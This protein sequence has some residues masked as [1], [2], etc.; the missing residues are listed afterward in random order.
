MHASQREYLSIGVS[1]WTCTVHRTR[2]GYIA[3]P[4]IFF[5]RLCI[6]LKL[7]L[8]FLDKHIYIYTPI[9]GPNIRCILKD[10]GIHWKFILDAYEKNFSYFFI[11]LTQ[12]CDQLRQ[13]CVHWVQSES[14][15]LKIPTTYANCAIN[16]ILFTH[17]TFCVRHF[18]FAKNQYFHAK[19]CTWP[20]NDIFRFYSIF[21]F[22]FKNLFSPQT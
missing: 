10:F 18:L 11:F 19:W 12:T 14:T 4:S 8:F 17:K 1:Q 3:F 20:H 2:V 13:N 22:S 9:C 7:R 6:C 16:A 5:R 15:W 21:N